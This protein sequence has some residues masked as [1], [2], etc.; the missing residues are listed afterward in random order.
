MQNRGNLE[1]TGRKAV[2][3]WIEKQIKE[4]AQLDLPAAPPAAHAGKAIR[5]DLRGLGNGIQSRILGDENFWQ[6]RGAG[7]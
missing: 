1:R 2:T 3:Q 7:P 5:E 4:S 6:L